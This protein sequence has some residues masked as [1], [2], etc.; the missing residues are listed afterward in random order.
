MAFVKAQLLLAWVK[1]YCPQIFSTTGFFSSSQL[2]ASKLMFSDGMEY[3][4]TS[5]NRLCHKSFL[6]RNTAWFSCQNAGLLTWPSQQVNWSSQLSSPA[7][8]FVYSQHKRARVLGSKKFWILQHERRDLRPWSPPSRPRT[9]CRS[10]RNRITVK[11]AR[12]F[13][14]YLPSTA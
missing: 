3:F 8:G 5:L 14:S 2:L 9:L 13:S 4:S 7:D 10:I 11:G 1:L 12:F 6:T